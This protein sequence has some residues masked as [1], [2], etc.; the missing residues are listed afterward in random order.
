MSIATKNITISPHRKSI[1]KIILEEISS[2]SN[3]ISNDKSMGL[4]EDVSAKRV[5]NLK[6]SK[7]NPYNANYFHHKS[8]NLLLKDLTPKAAQVH[9]VP[10]KIKSYREAQDSYYDTSIQ[11]ESSIHTYSLPKGLKRYKRLKIEPVT[12]NLFLRKIDK[13]INKNL[14]TTKKQDNGLKRGKVP[15]VMVIKNTKTVTLPPP[16]VIAVSKQELNSMLIVKGYEQ[17]S[18]RSQ[19][20]D[21]DQFK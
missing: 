20:K 18:A 13:A 19:A 15:A 9:D 7:L 3:T 5:I 4:K 8:N 21:K 17:N 16:D 1:T 11:A 2:P 14:T 6:K 10:S 12:K